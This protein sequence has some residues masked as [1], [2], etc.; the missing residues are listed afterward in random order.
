MKTKRVYI[1]NEQL[2]VNFTNIAAKY[3]HPD[4]CLI[5]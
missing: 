4:N 2:T 1:F 3:F 5:L